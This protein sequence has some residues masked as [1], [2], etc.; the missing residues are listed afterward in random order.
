MYPLNKLTAFIKS[1]ELNMMVECQIVLMTSDAAMFK[2]F[3]EQVT[4]NN[5]LPD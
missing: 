5:F 3:P 1:N 4:L 2:N